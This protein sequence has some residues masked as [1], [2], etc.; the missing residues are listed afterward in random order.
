M[1][2]SSDHLIHSLNNDHMLTHLHIYQSPRLSY[3]PMEPKSPNPYPP[4]TSLSLYLPK[5][6]T[7]INT[8]R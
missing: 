4:S 7:Q 3:Q 1:Q 2:S 5:P 8:K 6:Q